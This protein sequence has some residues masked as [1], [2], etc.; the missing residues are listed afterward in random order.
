ME[1]LKK[2]FSSQ[3]FL[4][5][6]AAGIGLLI[7]KWVKVEVD[8]ATI[9]QFVILVSGYLVGQGIADNGKGAAKVQGI[10]TL[11]ADKSVSDSDAKKAIEQ[12]KAV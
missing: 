3:K 11:T 8:Q 1:L 9:L 10:T 12:I 5:L 7:T 6:A 4:V 2:L